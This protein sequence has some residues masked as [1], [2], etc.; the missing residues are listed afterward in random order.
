MNLTVGV[1]G[2]G[3]IG[4]GVAKNI[5]KNGYRVLGFDID[6]NRLD[7]CMAISVNSIEEI[8]SQSHFLLVAVPTLEAY[9]EVM[10]II[11]I[12]ASNKL[13]VGDLCTFSEQTK[14]QTYLTLAEN[15]II[16]ID[17][18]VSG[19]RP[20]SQAGKLSMTVSGERPAYDKVETILNSFCRSVIY[21]GE[22]GVSIKIKYIL[23]LMI[24]I[25]NV[26][27]AEAFVMA[28]KVGIDL[29]LFTKV[30]KNSSAHLE[31]FDT[32]ADKW[33]T[34]NY[35]KDI[36]AALG[37]T[38]KDK[39][40]IQEFAAKHNIP[41]PLYEVAGKYYDEAATRGWKDQDAAV[42]LKLLEEK[43]GINRV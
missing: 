40:V 16:L 14:K 42:I 24:A 32:R 27:C 13:I 3:N 25:H 34:G 36:T 23:N 39:L 28:E 1:I 22:F 9:D 8:A 7:E 41:T 26:T 12:N 33:I 31:I 4:N 6:P 2:L 37:I 15:G 17:C 43:T 21:V 30:V 11:S 20:Q 29:E 18:P 5:A 38:L 35:D 10:Q 19:A